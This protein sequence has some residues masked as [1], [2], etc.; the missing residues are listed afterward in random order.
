M[1]KIQY[2]GKCTRWK[3]RKIIISIIPEAKKEKIDYIK[4]KSSVQPK[5]F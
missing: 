5:K 3:Y 4:V 2:N 1:L